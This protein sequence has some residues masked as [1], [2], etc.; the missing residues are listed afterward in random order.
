[1]KSHQEKNSKKKYVVVLS[2][3]HLGAGKIVDGKQNPLEDFVYDSQFCELLAFYSSE[4]FVDEEV[5]VVLNGDVFDL[6]AVPFVKYFDDEFWCQDSAVE[7]LR[8]IIGA[9]PKF[10]EGI[11]NYLKVN[12]K[13]LIYIIGNHDA[14]FIH[15]TVQD[16]FL[17]VIP[18]NLKQKISFFVT[19]N[20]AYKPHPELVIMHGHQFDVTFDEQN[21]GP[22]IVDRNNKRYYLPPWGAYYVTRILNK[23]KRERKFAGAVR[24]VGKFII[25]G[26]IYDTMFMVRFLLANLTY[27]FMV[28]LITIFKAEKTLNGVMKYLKYEFRHFQNYSTFIEEYLND[29]QI[30]KGL[31]V[32]HS[33]LPSENFI[34]DVRVINTGSWTKL[35]VLDMEIEREPIML[36]FLQV[37]IE[38]DK[39]DYSLNAWDGPSRL[40]FHAI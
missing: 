25:D 34:K 36:T 7:R 37:T 33:H 8:I 19:P 28:R 35:Y 18:E 12:N 3:L 5:E 21:D 1:M 31:V 2:D 13:K 22:I 29:H 16:E 17:K 32:G 39:L 11:V 14:E 40:P 4:E 6:L 10:I 26:L 9:H 38:N 24:P 30:V 23:F 15:Q 27:L 20:D